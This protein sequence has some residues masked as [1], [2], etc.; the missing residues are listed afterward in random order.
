M[1]ET[2]PKHRFYG[3]RQGRPLKPA[4]Q[5]AM[6]HLDGLRLPEGDIK[7]VAEMFP[8]HVKHFWLEVGFGNGEHLIGQLLQYPDVGFIGCE[9]FV[10]GVSAL[11]QN[12]KA[13]EVLDRVRI[14]PEDARP[15]LPRLP[16]ASFDRAF[17]LFS[18]PWPKA[19]HHR[20][21]F[22]QPE[23]LDMLARLLKPGSELRLATD[24]PDLAGWSIEQVTHHPAFDWRAE[25][26]QDWQQ[27]PDDWVGTRY[28]AKA[29]EQ[30]RPSFYIRSWR[31]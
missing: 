2:Q 4:R 28:Q 29:L 9:P 15:L 26:Q 6:N 23:T 14:H 25:S 8:S 17:V 3:R 19:R 13:A 27:A 11:I 16:A 21:R 18:D 22:I 10:N 7:N 1:T 24:D 5:E 12:A 31:K 30:G 20:R